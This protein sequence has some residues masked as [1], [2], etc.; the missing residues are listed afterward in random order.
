MSTTAKTTVPSATATP[1]SATKFLRPG[2]VV[3]VLT[4]RHAG[5]KAFIINPQDVPGK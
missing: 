3:V 2:K 4:G 1:A 5:K